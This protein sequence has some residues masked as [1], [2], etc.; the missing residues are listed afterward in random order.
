MLLAAAKMEPDW[1]RDNSI[2]FKGKAGAPAASSGVT[3]PSSA[4]STI[5]AVTLASGDDD[6]MVLFFPCMHE[7]CMHPCCMRVG[8]LGLLVTGS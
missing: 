8:L 4:T 2:K 5:Q 7:S 6:V 3:G 1:V